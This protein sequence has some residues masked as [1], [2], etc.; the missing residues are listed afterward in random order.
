[1]DRVL[2]VAAQPSAATLLSSWLDTVSSDT[3]VIRVDADY[4]KR[5]SVLNTSE[6]GGKD[7]QADTT[8]SVNKLYFVAQ[9]DRDLAALIGRFNDQP[10]VDFKCLMFFSSHHDSNLQMACSIVNFSFSF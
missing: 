5:A 3:E 6:F 2:I 10:Q 7:K 9:P 1:M 8:V 4:L